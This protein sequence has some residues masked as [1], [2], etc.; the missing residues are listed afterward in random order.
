MENFQL[1]ETKSIP[2][3]AIP[4]NKLSFALY[5]MCPHKNGNAYFQILHLLSGVSFTDFEQVDV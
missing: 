3:K 2:R 1:Q 5:D 4:E